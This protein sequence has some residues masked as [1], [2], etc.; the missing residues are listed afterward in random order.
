[1]T[2]GPVAVYGGAF[3]P[4]HYGHLRTAWELRHLIGCEQIR[5]VPTGDPPHR[6][7]HVATG[8]VRMRMLEAALTGFDWAVA[9]DRELRRAGPSYSVVTLAELRQSIGNNSLCMIVGMD[10]FLGL[11]HWHRWEELCE[12]AHIV[13]A[14]RPGWV[15][16]QH[17]ILGSL[18]DARR[19]DDVARLKNTSAGHIYVHAVTQLDIASSDIR[20]AMAAGL[21]PRFLVPQAVLDIMRATGCYDA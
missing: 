20:T 10:A 15:P 19:T 2:G 7:P 4:L 17:G 11:P 8:E 14:H 12:L 3:D 5:F 21:E 6:A 9:D 1:M 13:V 18:L 16:P